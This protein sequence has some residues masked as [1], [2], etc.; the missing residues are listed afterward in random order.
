MAPIHVSAE[1]TI[2]ARAQSLYALLADYRDG[3][4]RILPPAF[5]DC[6]VLYGG[7]GE[8]THIQFNVRVG[9]KT[10]RMVGQITEPEPGHILEE[11][12]EDGSVTRFTID[13]VHNE[14]RLRIET[15]AES[16]PGLAGLIERPLSRL[17]LSRLYREELDL[18][19]KWA[20]NLG[21]PYR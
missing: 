17:L 1:R 19:E 16:R 18:I 12:Y 2:P 20:E 8:G 5:S 6:R 14:S 9:G 13:P 11:T 15:S 10:R 7:T 3:H 21:S 4:P